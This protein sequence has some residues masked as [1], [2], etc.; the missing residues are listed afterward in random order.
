MYRFKQIHRN[1]CLILK[2][3]SVFPKLTFI[4][5]IDLLIQSQCDLLKNYDMPFLKFTWKRTN[6]QD[7]FE[8]QQSSLCQVLR[9]FN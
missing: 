6:S 8:E 9:L 2:N 4:L 3:K 7:N 1:E 5:Y